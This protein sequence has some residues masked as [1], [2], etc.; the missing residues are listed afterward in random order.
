MIA[1]LT[2]KIDTLGSDYL[3]IDVNGV[4]Y[5][6]HAS[7][8]TL[9][10]IGDIGSNVSL[11]IDM[12]V[13][14]DSMTLFGFAS[15]EEQ[16]WFRLLTSVQGVGAKV[17][18]AILGAC[19]AD[20]LVVA[21]MSDDKN[22]IRQAD[23]VGPKLAVRIITELKDKVAKMDL[24]SGVTMSAAPATA[25]AGASVNVAAGENDNQLN[26]DALSALVNLGYGRAE[27]Y[28]AVVTARSRFENDPELGVLISAG[29]KELA[30]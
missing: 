11:L 19:P 6:V 7:A 18:I 5:M 22:M 13:R 4:G 27:A 16:K 25:N 29:L 23:G 10:V 17:G 15:A 26:Q 1:K 2:G 14:E 12:Q 9:S 24:S 3:I 28:K 8:K 30:S 20:Q 21:V